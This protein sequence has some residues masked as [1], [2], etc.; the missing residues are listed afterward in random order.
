MKDFDA[1]S[2]G[3]FFAAAYDDH[4]REDTPATVDLLAGLVEPGAR[5]LELAVGT[6]RVALRLAER[7]FD[8]T[9]VDLSPE[10]L[11]ALRARP[12]ADAVTAVLGDLADPPVE[13]VFD[14]VFCVD[15]SL[16]NVADQ[17]GQV[18]AFVNA[19][20]HLAPGG[21]FV[22][23]GF[24]PAKLNRWPEDQRVA[25]EVVE[26]EYVQFEVEKHDRARQVIEKTHLVI[27]PEGPRFG[28]TVHR[29]VWPSELDLMARIAGLRLE[30][31]W[32]DWYRRPFGPRSEDYVCVYVRD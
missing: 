16:T 2:F 27:T 6:G 29:Y 9:G 28:P 20:A 21:R 30:H 15:N 3:R 10:M 11:D 4:P 8:V 25:V 13:G 19:A 12:G 14:L 32:T 24:V 17:D 22:V 5:V 18:R 26:P 31:R 7:G 23:D 1:A